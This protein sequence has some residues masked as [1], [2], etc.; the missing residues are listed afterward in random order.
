MFHYD[1]KFDIDSFFEDGRPLLFRVRVNA[2]GS[3]NEEHRTYT[4]DCMS[5]L[6]DMILQQAEYGEQT[7]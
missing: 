4:F 5:Y 7:D 2:L 1:P 6:D 3:P